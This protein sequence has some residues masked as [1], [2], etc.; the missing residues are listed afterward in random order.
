ML[1]ALTFAT[2]EVLQLSAVAIGLTLLG[3]RIAVLTRA[4]HTDELTR[5]PNRRGI[6]AA[7]KNFIRHGSPPT[8][9]LLDL[10]RFKSVND[11]HGYHAGD[12][13]LR[14][15]AGRLA[16]VAGRHH[17][18]AARLGGDEFALLLPAGPAEQVTAAI[19]QIEQALAAP[20][21]LDSGTVQVSVNAV[22]GASL[23]PAVVTDR[24]LRAADIALHYARHHGLP[25]VIYRPGMTYP[26]AESRHGPRLRD[27]SGSAPVIECDP[28]QLHWLTVVPSSGSA[29]GPGTPDQGAGRDARSGRTFV[30]RHCRRSW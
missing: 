29:A 7:M 23:P 30:R 15:V 12:E 26:A 6:A 9:L 2:L 19:S 5:L 21:P 4:A 27:T 16:V 28:D 24:P 8:V 13:L 20:V 3:R 22:F 10:R 25:W 1:S 11:R 17:G 14:H 18:V